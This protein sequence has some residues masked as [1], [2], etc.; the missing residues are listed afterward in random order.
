MS[1]A[2][3]RGG[4]IHSVGMK[5]TTL[6]DI[7]KQTKTSVSTVSRVLAGGDVGKRISHATSQRVRQAADL[8]GYRPNLVARTLRTHHSNTVALLVSDIANP[9]FSSI[10]SLVE[11]ALHRQGYSLMLC[12]SGEDPQREQDYLQMLAQK[13]IDGLIVVPMADTRETLLQNIPADLPLV[14]LDRPVAGINRAVYSDQEAS[15][16]QLALKLYHVGVQT[17]ALITSSSIITHRIRGEVMAN[18]FEVIFRHEGLPL[19]ETGRRAFIELAVKPDAI[20]CTNNAL[21]EGVIECIAEINHPPIIGTFDEIPVMHLLP[22]PMA[23]AMQDIPSLAEGC[24]VQLMRQLNGE[25]NGHKATV[26][27][28]RIITNRAFDALPIVV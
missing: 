26:L 17:I 28:A 4:A 9:F 11:Q 2:N 14:V 15:S 16:D 3:S 10:A 25:S 23:I 20:I 21:A 27:P 8:M 6:V 12:N 13:A 18:R 7:A 1:M 5:P 24:V 19:K 22:I